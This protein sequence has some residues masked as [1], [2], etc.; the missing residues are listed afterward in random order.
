[1]RKEDA[2]RFSVWLRQKYRSAEEVADAWNE[3]E[4]GISG[5]PFRTWEQMDATVVAMAAEERGLRGY[6]GEYGRVRDV[7]RYKA[8]ALTEKVGSAF[9]KF[10]E[11][12]PLVPTRTGGEM[13]LFLPFAWRATDM[14][15]LAETQTA[16]GS[17]YPSIHL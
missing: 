14:E 11:Q 12:Y 13:G 1:L 8:E 15:Q 6:G 2:A 9:G 7:L 5:Q 3:Y 16:T 4:V 17:F 10:H